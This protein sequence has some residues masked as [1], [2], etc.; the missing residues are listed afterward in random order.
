VLDLDM[1]TPEPQRFANNELLATAT[2]F[3]ERIYS[4]FREMVTDEFLKFY[5]GEL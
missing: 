4:V 1:F 5:G 3:S 2:R